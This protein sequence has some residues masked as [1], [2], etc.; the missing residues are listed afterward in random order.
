MVTGRKSSLKAKDNV[1]FTV[2]DKYKRHVSRLGFGT[3]Y[4]KLVS[5]A[6]IVP[7]AVSTQYE[8]LSTEQNKVQ[9]YKETFLPINKVRWSY[10]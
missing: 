1:S 8:K 6:Y 7:A 2:M 3:E 10:S 4:Y 9:Y 5:T